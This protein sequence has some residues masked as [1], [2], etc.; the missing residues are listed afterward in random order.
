MPPE[1]SRG[2]ALVSPFGFATS[3]LI[4]VEV[5]ISLENLPGKLRG[6]LRYYVAEKIERADP[7]R[8][9]RGWLSHTVKGLRRISERLRVW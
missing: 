8:R 7:L 5:S 2:Q 3:V 9:P 4:D 6:S 1:S